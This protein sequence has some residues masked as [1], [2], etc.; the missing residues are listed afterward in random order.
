MLLYIC[1][2][3]SC[4]QSAHTH[5]LSR[6]LHRSL[7][8]AIRVCSIPRIVVRFGYMLANNATVFHICARQTREMCC[9]RLLCISTLDL[10]NTHLTNY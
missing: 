9:V 7:S 10:I 4:T 5:T 2:K 8:L 1:L 3:L 6:S